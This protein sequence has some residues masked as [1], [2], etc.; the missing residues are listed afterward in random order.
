M[1]TKPEK[2]DEL[3]NMLNQLQKDVDDNKEVVVEDDDMDLPPINN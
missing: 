3:M 1:I 2:K